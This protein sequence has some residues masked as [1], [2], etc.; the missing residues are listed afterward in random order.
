MKRISTAVLAVA[1]M[2]GATGAIVAMPAFAK[3]KK[4]EAKPAPT[5][6]Q[7]SSKA[8]NDVFQKGRAALIAKDNA[9]AIAAAN[10]ADA[11]AKTDGDKYYASLLRYLAVGQQM[12]MAA[13]GTGGVTDSK[14]L[15]GPLEALIANPV[16]PKDQRA[17]FEFHR[18]A[19]AYDSKE[20]PVAVKMFTGAQADG[21][22]EKNLPFYLAKAKVQ[23]GDTAGGLADLGK[24]ADTG[25]QDEDIYRWG[26]QTAMAK[27]MKPEALAW[28][29]RW[30]SAYPTA[31]NWRDALYN[32]GLTA[33]PVTK[34][35]KRQQVDVFRLLRQTNGLADQAAYA[36]YGQKVMDLGLPDETKAIILEGRAKGKI[37]ASDS[38]TT[39]LL[40]SANTQI[41]AEGSFAA[42]EAKANASA[43]GALSAQT[44]DAY[45]G[46]G[47]YAKAVT[48]Y[49]QAL[50]KGGVTNADEV[51]LH[52]GI[53]LALSGDKAGAKTVLSA[54]TAAPYG[55]I[56]G[57]WVTW[58]D[59]PPVG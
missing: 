45:F 30:V 9:G 55:E 36:D 29:K 5:G 57:L 21:S 32:Y 42:L 47:E 31:K 38:L 26:I 24:L 8:F 50:T 48:L 10:E 17:K 22:T 15:I 19:I 6:P 16:T 40:N 34:L 49:R 23:A 18:G 28:L 59:H 7:I 39:T 25:T 54:I 11:A 37:P 56:A 2:G 35:I 53:A 46:R 12:E 58:I 14:P 1:M 41:T 43:T 44:G 3:D 33:A 27:G 20:Y 51:N 52:L 13:G 4:E